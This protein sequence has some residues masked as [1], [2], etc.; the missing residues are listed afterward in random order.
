MVH[1][2]KEQ[3]AR[4]ALDYVTDGM[5]IGLGTGS[6]AAIFIDLLGA[7]IGERGWDISAIPTS[8]A[9]RV[10][11]LRYDFK[12]IDADETTEIDVDIDGADEIDPDSNLIK[13]GGAA[14]LREK[15]VAAASKRVVIIADGSKDVPQLG[16]FPL[17]VEIDRF[18]WALTIV[19]IRET[20]TGLGYATPDVTLRPDLNKGGVVMSDGGH[21]I[22]DVKLGRIADAPALDRA[23]TMLPGVVTTGLFVGLSP[24]IL[25]GTDTGVERRNVH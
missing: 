22:V 4:A 7:K 10:Q 12:L 19:A 18:G 15:I 21:Y 11:A 16:A 3:A 1:S 13:G 17:P 6:T 14:L 5:T 8:E 9:S 25:I 20:L 23:L 2:A 24:T